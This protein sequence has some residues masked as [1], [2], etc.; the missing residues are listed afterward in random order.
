MNYISYKEYQPIT[1]SFIKY[2]RKSLIADEFLTLDTET[3][4][5]HALNK[6]DLKGWVYQWAFYDGYNVVYGR[7]PSDLIESLDKIVQFHS[8]NENKKLL[9]FI[10]NMP[11]DFQY[12]KH[13][14]IQKWGYPQILAYANHKVFQ[15]TFDNG[16]VFR[17]SYKL[18]NKSLEKW[19]KDL[20]I[21]HKKLVGEIDYNIIRFQDSKLNR[22]DW[23]Y[24]FRDVISQHECIEQTLID[25]NDTTAT[26]PLTSTSYVR[27][28]I[29]REY[30]KDNRNYNN[31]AKSKL[32]KDIYKILRQE[33]SGGITHGNRYFADTTV[34]GIIRHRDFTSH[35]PTQQRIHKFGMSKFCL[36]FDS[37]TTKKRLKI[38]DI[39][40]L[41]I[42]NSVFMQVVIS[43]MYLISD[44][45]T[46]PYAQESKFRYEYERGTTFDCDNGRILQMKGKSRL[47][48][49][50]VDLKILAKQ[51]HF[52]YLIEKVYISKKDYLPDFMSKVIDDHFKGKS[53]YKQ[54]VK[55][56][57]KE[58]ASID[59]IRDAN[60]NLMKSKNVVNGIYGCSATDIV[61]QEISLNENISEWEISRIT[62][63][64]I[65]ESIDKYYK[66]RNNFM[67]YNWGCETTQHAREQ[68]M[69]VISEIIGYDNFLYCDTDS[70]FYISTPEIERK[71]EAYNKAMR[72]LCDRL[73]AYVI[74][75]N[76]NK[77][78]YNQFVDED[79]EIIEFRFLHS[80][81]YA[82]V[83]SDK[84][85]H[86]TIA[87]VPSFNKETG[88]TR[89]Q[90]LGNID[91]LTH[92]FE[93]VQCG[94]KT[95]VY[96]ENDPIIEEID[97]HSIEYS[98]SAVI[99]DSTKTLKY[100]IDQLYYIY[101]ETY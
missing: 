40:K 46:M 67:R 49:S 99:Q 96:V 37:T 100:D 45:I 77:I 10:H 29:R 97:G 64:F 47:C 16:L 62:D 22:S 8:L 59:L 4:N 48:L 18:S 63:D 14:M 58:N 56:L 95:C 91:N 15:A 28:E 12:L 84:K 44:R 26:I 17:C 76:G 3:S 7:K 32:T 61:K 80:K 98:A 39:E 11:Y 36:F 86:C 23:R 78:Y 43:D 19:G 92:G 35:Y 24:M 101:N 34:K 81:C 89:E 50:D 31:F 13:Y 85:L 72:A 73:G 69:F 70:C 53:D 93:F 38:S 88:I 1:Y 52:S 25:Y 71:F 5:N 20:N 9:I 57:E 83:T 74:D 2:K 55:E 51:Y 42:E 87:G 6:E 30:A 68:L 65:I 79:E 90:E 27:R 94:G 75:K 60:T 41:S 21:K 54:I 33:F 66:S 82:Y